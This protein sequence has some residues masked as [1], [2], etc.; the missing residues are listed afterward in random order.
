MYDNTQARAHLPLGEVEELAFRPGEAAA[1]AP[2]A[3][4]VVA[5]GCD[6]KHLAQHLGRRRAAPILREELRHILPVAHA[7]AEVVGVLQS[8]HPRP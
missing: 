6:L 1:R 8:P 4:G 3:L 2:A 7:A 5:R